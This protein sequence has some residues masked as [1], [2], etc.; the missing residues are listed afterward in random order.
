M[1]GRVAVDPFRRR[2]GLG[3]RGAASGVA[4]V[5]PRLLPHRTL[6]LGYDGPRARGTVVTTSSVVVQDAATRLRDCEWQLLLYEAAVA[7][8]WQ[9]GPFNAGVPAVQRGRRR[10]VLHAA[11]ALEG[12]GL[13]LDAA[14]DVGAEVAR[15]GRGFVLDPPEWGCRLLLHVDVRRVGGIGPI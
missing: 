15:Q 11:D 3:E 10:F 5:V 2:V 4:P 12:R 1:L 9:R 7:V 13:L 6:L 8:W 14:F